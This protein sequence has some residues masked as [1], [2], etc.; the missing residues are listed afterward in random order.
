MADVLAG[1]ERA[2]RWSAHGIAGVDLGEADA[3][4]GEAVDVGGLDAL[5]SVAAEVAVTEIVGEDENNI[6]LGWGVLG[7]QGSGAGE[8]GQEFSSV[9]YG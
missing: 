6:G 1:H 9:H 3:I 5:L 2:A 7:R 4:G 8:A